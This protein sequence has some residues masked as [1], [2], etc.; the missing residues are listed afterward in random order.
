MKGR[1]LNNVRLLYVI[2]FISM[3]HLLYFVY[4]KDNASIFLFAVVALIVYIFN[5]N[6]ILVLLACMIVV[7]FLIIIN[8]INKE[9][10]TVPED[11]EKE[12]EKEK[13]KIE[14]FQETLE[15]KKLKETKYPEDSDN[16]NIQELLPLM[17]AIDG[18]DMNEINR[19]L[20]NFNNIIEKF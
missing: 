17:N 19:M 7:D 16:K 1:I 13:D 12:K 14:H 5:T 11:K 2:F 4:N 20:N 18:L 3:I 10:L 8:S 6:M 15:S 9:G